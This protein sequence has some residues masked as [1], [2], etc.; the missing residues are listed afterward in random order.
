VQ[1]A[2]DD[3]EGDI[4]IEVRQPVSP[5]HL[6]WFVPVPG[7]T[8][9]LMIVMGIFLVLFTMM[10]GVLRL[11]HLPEHIAQKEQKIQYQIVAILC[12]L[13]M[14]TYQNILW[15]AALLL[16]MIDLPDFTGLFA[17]IAQSVERIAWRKRPSL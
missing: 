1:G 8:D 6:P 17:R 12:L 11:H 2:A 13:A 9:I 10:V 14:F 7:Q 5:A 4:M 3:A 15:V 16:A